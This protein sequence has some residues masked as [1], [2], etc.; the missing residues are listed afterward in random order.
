MQELIKIQNIKKKFGKFT[1]LEDINLTVRKGEFLSLLGPSGCGK[2]TLLRIIA[3]LENEDNGVIYLGGRNIS[4]I[5]ARKRGFG[6]VFQSYAL[7]PNMSAYENIAFPLRSKG[8][9]EKEIEGKCEVLLECLELNGIKNKLPRQLSGGQQQR[10]ALGRA[11]ALSP[12]LLLLDEPLSALDAKVREKLRCQ[13]KK[14]QKEL[15]VTTIMVTHDQDEALSMSDRIA[16]MNNGVIEQ[17]GTPEEIYDTPINEFVANFIGTSNLVNG[18][19]FRPEEG[20]I[21]LEK[22][23]NS[24]PI[25]VVGIEFRGSVYRVMCDDEKTSYIIDIPKNEFKDKNLSVG[26]KYYLNIQRLT[27]L[28]E[29]IA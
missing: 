22:L 5:S 16:I 17:I 13:I 14:V 26:D 7:F 18:T 6:I 19:Y 29:G 9:S 10:V 15:G 11:L 28:K 21:S 20:S 2:T 3:G 8:I 25:I 27:Q 23:I 1:A 24:I 4:K 12:Q